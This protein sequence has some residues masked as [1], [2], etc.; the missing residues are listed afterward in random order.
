MSY[1][2]KP[3]T[4]AVLTLIGADGKTYSAKVADGTY[5]LKDVKVGE[6]KVT[7]DADDPKNPNKAVLIP[8]KYKDEE[9]TSL[10]LTVRKGEAEYDIDLE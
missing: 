2:G 6:Y 7:V 8:A 3:V 9:K 5:S 1:K 10:R 4:A